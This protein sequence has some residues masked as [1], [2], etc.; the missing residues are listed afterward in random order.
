MIDVHK[1]QVTGVFETFVLKAEV[2]KVDCSHLLSLPSPKYKETIGQFEHL[3]GVTM[4]DTDEK[5]KLRI[6]LIIGAS[7]YVK[8][9]TATQPRVGNTGELGEL[10]TFGWTIMSPGANVDLTNMLFTQS[11]MHDYQKLCDLDV[12]GIKKPLNEQQP[13]YE[14]FKEQ[15]NQSEERWYKTGLLW[16]PRVDHLPSNKR[17]SPARLTKLVQR[18]EKKPDLLKQYEEIIEGQERQGIIEKAP[19][20]SDQKLFY[21]PHKPVVKES[22]ETTKVRIVYDAS[23]RATDESPLH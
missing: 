17:G 23:A 2:T 18:L 8:F 6:R 5:E 11:S 10:T 14:D 4:D 9:K 13:V 12:P 20:E 15:L 19:Q 1:L 3:K 7:D 16:K 21:I 22:A